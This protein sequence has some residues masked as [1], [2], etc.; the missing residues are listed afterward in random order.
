VP[1]ARAEVRAVCSKAKEAAC[2]SIRSLRLCA[3]A[4]LPFERWEG[5]I[6]FF[7]G[8]FRFWFHP[9]PTRTRDKKN[10]IKSPRHAPKKDSREF[11]KKEKNVSQKC[12]VPLPVGKKGEQA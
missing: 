12:G 5:N 6:L 8:V 4:R 7:R 9:T 11:E 10:R 1:V 2:R 3:R